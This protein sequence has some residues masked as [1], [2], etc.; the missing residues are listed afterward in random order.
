MGY[1]PAD[2]LEAQ[3]NRPTGRLESV[4]EP[5]GCAAVGLRHP[6]LDGRDRIIAFTCVNS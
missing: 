4:P 5:A 3:V 6:Y 2:L 1:K